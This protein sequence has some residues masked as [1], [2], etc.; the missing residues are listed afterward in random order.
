DDIIQLFAGPVD[1]PYELVHEQGGLIGDWT[2]NE[3]VY[4]VPEGQDETRFM[5][6]AKNYAIGNLLDKVNFA[7]NNKILSSDETLE[8][9]EDSV[10]L[11]ANGYGQWVEGEE[12][13][14]SVEIFDIEGNETTVS[15]FTASGEYTFIWKTRYCEEIVTVT[16][17]GLDEIPA[18]ETPIE[19]CQDE[20]AEPLFAEPMEDY[21]LIFL[22]EVDGEAV[23]SLTPDT[24]EPGTTIY[25]T[26]YENEEGCRSELAEIEVIVIELEEPEVEFYY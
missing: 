21:D 26:A 15:G 11:E 3:G 14:A 12:N 23:E 18:V 20:E 8:C 2:W 6:V 22:T 10:S 19:Y 13:P 5:F 17:E 9:D 25:Y 4:E 16:Y 7:P 1:G 24:S